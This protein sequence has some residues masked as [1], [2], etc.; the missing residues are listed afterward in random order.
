[1]KRISTFETF[2]PKKLDDREARQEQRHQKRVEDL[3]QLTKTIN[4]KLSELKS[5]TSEDAFEQEF[6]NSIG[7]LTAMIGSEKPFDTSIFF[8]NPEG[9]CLVCLLD[10]LYIWLESGNAVYNIIW[11]AKRKLIG[12]TFASALDD[13]KKEFDKCFQKYLDIDSPTITY[14]DKDNVWIKD[15]TEHLKPEKSFATFE[16]FVPKK[17]VGRNQHVEDLIKNGSVIFGYDPNGEVGYRVQMFI[18]SSGKKPQDAMS[19]IKKFLPHAENLQWHSAKPTGYYWI[20]LFEEDEDTEE[21]KDI[22]INFYKTMDEYKDGQIR[23]E[24]MHNMGGMTGEMGTLVE[25][26]KLS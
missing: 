15:A 9:E 24:F 11:K 6:I 23:A 13:A 16:T 14:F 1:M 2:V 18:S 22:E 3:R 10:G 7:P 21:I 26:R 19:E 12:G 25:L 17:L 5:K 8:F 4:S 20:L